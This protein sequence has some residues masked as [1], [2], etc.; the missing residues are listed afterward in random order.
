MLYDKNWKLISA[1]V[2]V[3][4]CFVHILLLHLMMG[5]GAGIKELTVNDPEAHLYK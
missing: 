1:Y 3:C 5:G 2:Y 4:A